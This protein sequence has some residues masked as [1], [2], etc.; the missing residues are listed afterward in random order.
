MSPGTVQRITVVVNG[1]PYAVDV[2]DLMAWPLTVAVNGVPYRVEIQ[3][4]TGMLQADDSP[5]D[6]DPG[7]ETNVAPD[8]SPVGAASAPASPAEVRAP[9]PGTITAVYA[10]P[11]DRVTAGQALC[12][13]EAM[14]MRNAIRATRNGNVIGV[15]IDPGQTVAYGDLL[16][17]LV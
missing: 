17:T 8:E 2:G 4:S 1:T 10:R 5:D 13:L 12:T 9:M 6:L 15:T 3:P 7:W 16:F 11:G 14:K